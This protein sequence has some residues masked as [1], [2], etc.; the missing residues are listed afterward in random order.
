MADS[1]FTQIIKKEIPS[2]T[3][4]EDEVAIA[5]LDIHPVNKGHVLVVPKVQYRSIYDTPDDVLAHVMIVA[6][7]LS[8]AIK[9]AVK[10]DGISIVMSNDPAAGQM[11]TDHMHIHVIPR[12]IGDGYRDW[13]GVAMYQGTEMDT[14][15]E[16]IR[17]ACR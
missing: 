17:N 1:I 2:S 5:F 8:L 9:E 7:K 14:Y 4:Y 12:H 3:V 10:A 11:V 15:A 6:K 13:I 16:N